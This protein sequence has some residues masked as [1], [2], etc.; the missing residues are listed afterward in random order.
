M[1]SSKR[2]FSLIAILFSTIITFSNCNKDDVKCSLDHDFCASIDIEKYNESGTAI[3]KFLRTQKNSLSDEKKLEQLKDWLA[4]KSCVI[5][6][7][8]LCVSCIRTNPPQSEIKV[9]FNINGQK[10]E[11]ILDI[12]MDTELK[13]R[14]FHE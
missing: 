12:L 13:F 10:K 14:N 11:M 7:K 8:I 9:A 1:I 3:N 4:C 2:K 6:A 5:D